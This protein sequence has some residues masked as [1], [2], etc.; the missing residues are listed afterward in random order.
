MLASGERRAGALG[1][2]NA[3]HEN[4]KRQIFLSDGDC[5][6][7][8]P[9]CAGGAGA[10]LF[11]YAV[12]RPAEA[13]AQLSASTAAARQEGRAT[14]QGAR[15]GGGATISAPTYNQYKADA[16]E[17]VKFAEIAIPPQPVAYDANVKL[18]FPDLVG[19]LSDFDLF[20]EKG[21]ASAMISHY[22]ADAGF[23]LGDR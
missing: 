2:G 6:I 9:G 3:A 15:S 10:R 1:S 22:S 4:P 7:A 18:K 17:R 13:R 19:S 20:A 14:E 16:L 23:H 5:A 11:R 21:I 12:R 8:E